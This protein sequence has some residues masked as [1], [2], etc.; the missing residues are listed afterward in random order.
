MAGEGLSDW[1]RGEEIGNGDREGRL[2]LE[3]RM[4]APHIA[5]SGTKGDPLGV[6]GGVDLSDSGG[7]GRLDDGGVEFSTLVDRGGDVL[8]EEFWRDCGSMG[9][10][11]GEVRGDGTVLS[12]GCFVGRDGL[13]RS[14]ETLSAEPLRWRDGL[15]EGSPLDSVSGSRSERIPS[16]AEATS[17]GVFCALVAAA[18]FFVLVASSSAKLRFTVSMKASCAANSIALLFTASLKASRAATLR[19][20][21]S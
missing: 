13:P 5:G 16:V 10:W 21:C 18:A 15:C 8:F 7:E 9:G 6:F 19:H 20:S 11:R 1:G 14:R 4:L 12:I 2:L 3:S 17:D